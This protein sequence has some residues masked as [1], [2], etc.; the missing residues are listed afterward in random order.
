M[1]VKLNQLN[2][3]NLLES[4]QGWQAHA[5][6]GNTYRLRLDIINK[7]ENLFPYEISSLEINKIIKST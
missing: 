4:F 5:R 6:L 7:I 1:Y 2:Y 3:D